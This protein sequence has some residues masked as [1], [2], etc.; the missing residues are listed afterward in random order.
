MIMSL[1]GPKAASFA[2]F[3]QSIQIQFI[4][5]NLHQPRP[6]LRLSYGP[7]KNFIIGTSSD[8]I[9]DASSIET[10][11]E[12][13]HKSFRDQYFQ[14]SL[15]LQ[16]L[17]LH[18]PLVASGITE[19]IAVGGGE[20]VKHSRAA[21]TWTLLAEVHTGHDQRNLPYGYSMGMISL[22]SSK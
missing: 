6:C 14:S 2:S 4:A 11:F 21:G 13:R 22:F 5:G 9:A 3:I 8:L 18:W 16:L 7:F 20:I 17:V 15:L 12:G 1:Q 19:L 10:P